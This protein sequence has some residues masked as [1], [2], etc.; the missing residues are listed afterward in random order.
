[1]RYIIALCAV[2]MNQR[3][4]ESNQKTVRM[5]KQAA[6]CQLITVLTSVMAVILILAG[7]CDI[8]KYCG[9]VQPASGAG[10]PNALEITGLVRNAIID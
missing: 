1:M 2:G 4:L 9:L 7:H 5:L 10:Q 3:V 8:K 6:S